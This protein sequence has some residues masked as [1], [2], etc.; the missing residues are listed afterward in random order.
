M[1]KK[2]EK[3]VTKERLWIEMWLK[4]A[5]SYENLKEKLK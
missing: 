3:K 4:D 2:D 5:R 1:G